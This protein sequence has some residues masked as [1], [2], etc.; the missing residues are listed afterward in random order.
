MN[1]HGLSII[2]EVEEEEVVTDESHFGGGLLILLFDPAG[3]LAVV[4]FDGAK[5]LEPANAR[6]LFDDF[7]LLLVGF[8]FGVAFVPLDGRFVVVHLALQVELLLQ[9]ALR[10]LQQRFHE[11]EHQLGLFIRPCKQQQS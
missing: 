3:I 4:G 11:R 9:I 7:V 8:E 2:K 6:Q 1:S 5:E 10:L